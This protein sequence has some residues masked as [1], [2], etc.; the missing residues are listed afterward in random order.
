MQ[1]KKGAPYS[2]QPAEK[3][4]DLNSIALF[5]PFPFPYTLFLRVP[6]CRIIGRLLMVLRRT[7]RVLLHRMVLRA[8]NIRILD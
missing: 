8:G 5:C 6:P 1:Q 7:Q 4:V 3:H 2:V